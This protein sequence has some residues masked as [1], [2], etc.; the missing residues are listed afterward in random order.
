MVIKINSEEE[1]L[2]VDAELIHVI[3]NLRKFTKL[4]EETHGVELKRNKKYYELKA[5]ELIARLQVENHKQ[6]YEIKIEV[7]AH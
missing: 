4:W 5:D 1:L 7:D 3:A 2:N 6:V